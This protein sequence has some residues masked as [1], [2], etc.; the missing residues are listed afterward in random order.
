MQTILEFA[1]EMAVNAGEILLKYFDINGIKTQIKPDKT[2]VTEAD[3]AADDYIKSAI[4]SNHPND[5]IL[6]EESSQKIGNTDQAVWV[7]DPLDGTTNF[8]FGLPIWGVSIARIVEQ[9]PEIAALYFPIINEL[10][11]AQK[12]LG[13][14]L[15]GNKIMTKGKRK[16]HPNGFFNC[17][18]RSHRYFNITIPYKT[19]ILGSAAYDFCAVARGAA[20]LGFQATAKIWDLAAGY[21]LLEEAGG[22]AEV[23][24][25]PKPFPLSSSIDYQDQSYAT[26]MAAN[27]NLAKKMKTYLIPKNNM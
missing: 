27:E 20:I 9:V 19:R 23:Y 1:S 18:T 21:L 26:I 4:Q 17:C 10:Y 5:L 14:S 2:V 22:V 16:N 13:A 11:I 24:H 7:I 3:Y 25:P 12:G 8:S 15:N 6:S